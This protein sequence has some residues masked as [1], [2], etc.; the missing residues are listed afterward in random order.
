MTLETHSS[1]RFLHEGGSTEQASVIRC[2]M[3]SKVSHY[4]YKVRMTHPEQKFYPHSFS[5]PVL[6]LSHFWWRIC[7]FDLF[8]LC[9]EVYIEILNCC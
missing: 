3:F 8:S 4:V 1:S 9:A 7:S 6:V 2:P 5:V